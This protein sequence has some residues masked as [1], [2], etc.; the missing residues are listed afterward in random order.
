MIWIVLAHFGVSLLVLFIGI[1]KAEKEK[2]K[3]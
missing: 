1:Y 2:R 3:V